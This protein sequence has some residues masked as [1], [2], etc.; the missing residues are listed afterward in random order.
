M[1]RA[2]KTGAGMKPVWFPAGD[3]GLLLDLTGYGAQLGGLP[4]AEDRQA[5]TRFARALAQRIKGL[6]TA[7]QLNGITDLV[8]GL[9]SLLVH[10][11]PLQIS[12]AEIKKNVS[13]ILEAPDDLAHTPA[14][15]WQL[16]VLY[17][18]EAGPDLA[19]VASR[20]K[21]SEAQVI[22]T[23]ATTML[24]VGIMGF[25]PGLAYMT[26]LHPSLHLPRRTEP[27][28]HVA[29]GSVAIA[30]DQTVIY[31]L[32]SPG[33]WNLIG[34][35]PIPLFDARRVEPVLLKAGERVSFMPINAGEYRK[36]QEACKDGQLPIAPIQAG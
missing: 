1:N 22:E 4:P 19:E 25:L 9:A 33:G 8:P 34:L 15:T 36:L 30:M 18:A 31:P 21:M 32:D 24:E 20:C 2:E 27:R 7:G 14:R 23:H 3:R 5:F 35:M 16:P 28:T 10:Y 12:A 6:L 17:G 11:D 13:I 26:G 29:G